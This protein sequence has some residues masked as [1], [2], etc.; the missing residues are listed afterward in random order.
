MVPMMKY[1]ASPHNTPSNAVKTE[2]LYI[3]LCFPAKY[4]SHPAAD[5]LPCGRPVPCGRPAL[6]P[7]AI[8]ID[9]S[10]ISDPFIL[11][12]LSVLIILPVIFL[13]ATLR[14]G[15]AEKL[16]PPCSEEP[17]QSMDIVPCLRVGET[18]DNS[19]KYPIK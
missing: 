16:I 1:G 18:V 10:A 19:F 9:V 7:P 2:A 3:I 14:N 15:H 8:L 4:I 12:V 11:S 13:P 5:F 6:L 17:F